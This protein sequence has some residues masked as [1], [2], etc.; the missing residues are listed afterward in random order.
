[1]KGGDDKKPCCV[2]E[3]LL[4][5]FVTLNGS[6]C[7]GGTNLARTIERLSEAQ[8]ALRLMDNTCEHLFLSGRAGTGKSALL[9]HFRDTRP[10]A[11]NHLTSRMVTDSLGADAGEVVT[12]E[13]CLP[14]KRT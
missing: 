6:P 5:V 1:M 9:R 8:H 7:M 10:S 4:R 12:H 14:H 2:A 13:P 11:N 3:T